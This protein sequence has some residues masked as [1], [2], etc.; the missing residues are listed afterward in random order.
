M[1]VLHVCVSM[2]LH[3][4]RRVMQS[5]ES[6]GTMRARQHSPDLV[7]PASFPA[8]Y[9]ARANLAAPALAL[10]SFL[11]LCPFCLPC[12]TFST[13]TVVAV[14][15]LPRGCLLLRI[16]WRTCY[17]PRRQTV[18]PHPSTTHAGP[19]PHEACLFSSSCLPLPGYIRR[20]AK[21][22][23]PSLYISTFSLPSFVSF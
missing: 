22:W 9:Q 1:G 23:S 7:L 17:F 4:Q 18:R 12:C 6:L 16:S 11:P 15:A 14:S 21:T 5:G 13:P 2:C 20:I 19:W 10:P 8:H 3:W